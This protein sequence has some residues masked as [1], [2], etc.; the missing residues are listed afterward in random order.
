M[1]LDRERVHNFLLHNQLRTASGFT[2]H[3]P[4]YE[5]NSPLPLLPLTSP[6]SAFILCLIPPL[7][8]PLQT[9]CS[10]VVIRLSPAQTAAE[11]SAELAKLKA[12][13]FPLI[14][15]TIKV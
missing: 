11:R 15:K 6:L 1:L 4:A 12:L 8:L 10:G 9:R 13:R 5:P 2:L 14:C 7:P 3:V